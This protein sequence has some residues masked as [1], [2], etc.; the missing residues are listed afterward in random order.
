MT[1]FVH[2]FIIVVFRTTDS[3][4]DLYLSYSRD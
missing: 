4:N 2:F 1:N 3:L